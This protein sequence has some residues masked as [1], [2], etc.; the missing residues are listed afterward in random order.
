MLNKSGFLIRN[1]RFKK[2]MASQCSMP[3]EEN[4]QPRIP[5]PG[6][7]YL[8]KWTRNQDSLRWRKTMRL[9]NQL[10]YSKW[11]VKENFWNRKRNDK[12]R[13][14]EHPKRETMFRAKL[15]V[16]TVYFSSPFEFSILCLIV[17]MKII[18]VSNVVINI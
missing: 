6:E 7:I 8:Q 3:K 14:F 11:M 16:N 2:E 13:N 10:T 18:T 5:Y 4:Y 15:W 9:L 17:E 1:H 12:R